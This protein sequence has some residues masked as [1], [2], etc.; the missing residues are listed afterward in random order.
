MNG[1]FGVL[2][3]YLNCCGAKPE[4]VIYMFRLLN[5]TTE[6]YSFTL[7]REWKDVLVIRICSLSA[8]V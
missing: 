5:I 6:L 3:M 8:Q 4:V 7:E 1:L 2:F